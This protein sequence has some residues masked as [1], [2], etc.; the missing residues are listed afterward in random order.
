MAAQ[1][2]SYPSLQKAGSL[3]K[4]Q[5]IDFSEAV[6]PQECPDCAKGPCY[7][8]LLDKN[9]EEIKELNESNEHS[10]YNKSL[11][12][13]GHHP[14]ISRLSITSPCFGFGTESFKQSLAMAPGPT[15]SELKDLISESDG[16]EKIYILNSSMGS[17]NFD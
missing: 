5:V 2:P 8:H 11:T 1:S 6:L 4:K 15:K 10:S 14:N 13:G 12:Q 7:L 3:Q 17:F 16:D 9:F